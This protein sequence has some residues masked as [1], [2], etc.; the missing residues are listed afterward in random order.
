MTAR[1][2]IATM[3]LTACALRPAPAG[4]QPGSDPS[5]QAPGP[6][7]EKTS[8][9]DPLGPEDGGPALPEGFMLVGDMVVPVDATAN[10]ASGF[11][12]TSRPWPNGI[13][14]IV[15]EAGVTASQRQ[16]LFTLCN[17]VWGSVSNVRCVD[18]TTEARYIHVTKSSSGCFAHLGTH[19]VGPH[20]MNLQDN[21]CWTQRTVLHEIGH[22]LG[23]MHEHQRPERDQFIEVRLQ[24]V[25][26]GVES[27]FEIM[28]QSNIDYRTNVYDFGSIMHYSATAAS[29]N[30]QPTM[31]ARP[32]Y[33]AIS[34]NFGT[35][36]SPSQY[37]HAV[38]RALY[39]AAA[40]VSLPGTPTAFGTNIVGTRVTM[41]WG[42]PASGGTPTSYV[43]SARSVVGAI[44]GSWD[45]GNVTS[46]YG[47]FA[48][49][50][51]VLSVQAKNTAGTGAAATVQVSVGNAGMAPAAPANLLGRVQGSTLTLSWSAPVAPGPAPSY[52]L[53]YGFTPNF[54]TGY[55][56]ELGTNTSVSFP[57]VPAGTFYMRIV[58][59][60]QHGSSGASNEVQVVVGGASAPAAPSLM[61][62]ESLGGNV[63]KMQWQPGAGAAATSYLLDVSATPDGVAYAS[64]PLT[65]TSWTASAPRGIYYLRLRAVNAAGTSA[66]S[67]TRTLNAQ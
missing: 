32:Q 20:Q 46:A 27:Q 1:I 59:R 25:R 39:G 15:F 37:D 12:V 64:M 49:G 40:T 34:A 58:A 63:F 26:S 60:T 50:T 35:G 33:A 57:G 51:Y 28:R 24:N 7:R 19:T 47:E 31:V 13:L 22:A 44:L 45:V 43:I 66:P 18:R 30:G 29:S 6:G 14:P 41:S 55:Q 4:A 16:T 3:L 42:A 54:A 38:I 17:G 11:Y 61:P 65:G 5:L 56:V 52:V 8:D 36:T 62:V 23:L 2:L 67:A 48:V 21:A 10:A 53:H 9:T